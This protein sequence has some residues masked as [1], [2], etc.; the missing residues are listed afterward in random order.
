[1]TQARLPE[2]GCCSE[3]TPQL[4]PATSTSWRFIRFCLVGGSGV[5]VDMG[6]FFLFAD[7]RMLA[8]S[9][10]VAKALAAETAIFNN[11]VWN[12]LWTFRDLAAGHT[13]WRHR[14][15][16]LAKFNLICLAG[17][18]WSILLLNFQVSILGWNA[19]VS[20]LLAI[21]LVS[22]WNFFM[23]LKFGWRNHVKTR[24]LQ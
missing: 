10:S 2:R 13:T 15:T 16:R 4:R 1:M 18:V 11:F 3:P 12:E 6:A 23:N 9:L 24:S 7:P 19:Y 21:V 8:L 20:N 14:A 5:F 22:L 17:I